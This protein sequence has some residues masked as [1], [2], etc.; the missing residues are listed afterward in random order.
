MVKNTKLGLLIF[1]T[2][3][4]GKLNDILNKLTI[5]KYE[6]LFTI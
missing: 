2:D 4:L 3:S 5:E 1:C 6:F